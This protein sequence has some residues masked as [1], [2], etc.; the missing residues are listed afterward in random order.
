MAIVRVRSAT[1]RDVKTVDGWVLVPGG[2][3]AP[4]QARE[5]AEALKA[6]ATIADASARPRAALKG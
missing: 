6:A 1:R 4:A 2:A 3:L 5:M